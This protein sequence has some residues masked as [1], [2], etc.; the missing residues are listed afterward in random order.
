MASTGTPG[1][2]AIVGIGLRF[3]GARGPE[4][5]WQIL[6]DG[7]D[8]V[9]EIRPTAGMRRCSVIPTPAPPGRWSV[10]AAGF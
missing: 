7:V 5:L 2:I 1:A 3:P 8:A 9:T 10:A 4:A 6:S